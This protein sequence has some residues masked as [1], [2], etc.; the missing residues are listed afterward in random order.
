MISNNVIQVQNALIS[1]IQNSGLNIAETGKTAYSETDAYQYCGVV[2]LGREEK[3]I[4]NKG[5]QSTMK[6]GIAVTCR[7]TVS[8]SDAYSQRDNLVDNG[9]GT[10]V[11]PLLRTLTYNQLGGLITTAEIKACSYIDSVGLNP[12]SSS[13]G[14]W[15]ASAGIELEVITTISP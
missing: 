3:I 10:G 9:S 12:K 2:L 6:F 15:T 13:A 5:R 8:L 7:S 1:L 11:E 4:A 14:S